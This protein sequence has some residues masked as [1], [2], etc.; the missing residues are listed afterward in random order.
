MAL[1]LDALGAEFA[2]WKDLCGRLPIVNTLYLGGGTPTVLP[3][4]LWERLMGLLDGALDFGPCLEATV[5]ANP[6]SLSPDH[7]H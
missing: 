3:P 4:H 5:E 6:G 2:L 1:Y 7:L